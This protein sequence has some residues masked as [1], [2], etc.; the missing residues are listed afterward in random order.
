MNPCSSTLI[1]ALVRALKSEEPLRPLKCY[2]RQLHDPLDIDRTPLR[3]HYS[4]YKQR[5]T[6]VLEDRTGDRA[7]LAPEG[8]RKTRRVSAADCQ[9]T[10]HVFKGST[11]IDPNNLQTTFPAAA[12]PAPEPSIV[13]AGVRRGG[14]GDAEVALT[15]Y[16]GVTHAAT[17]SQTRTTT[18]ARVREG[19][20]RR[21]GDDGIGERLTVP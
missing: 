1:R 4:N 12:D 10:V 13:H 20:R 16:S 5:T 6:K 21:R 3:S 11:R 19:V 2:Q 7:S 8:R 15:I 17:E 9:T 14:R 18:P